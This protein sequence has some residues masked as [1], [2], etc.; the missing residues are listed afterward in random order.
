MHTFKE[1]ILVVIIGLTLVMVSLATA[2]AV[3][4]KDG[5]LKIYFLDVGQGDAILIE[6]P[7]GNQVLIDGGPD[8]KILSEL[9]KVMPFY[10]QSIDA[11]VVSHPHS[12]HIT[13]LTEV[14]A[15]YEVSNII[16][17]NENYDSPTFRSW[18]AAVTAEHTHE[19]EA[20]A[21]TK[22]ALAPEVILT[23]IHP[24]QSVAGTTTKTP[25]DDVVVAVLEYRSLRVLLTGDM[26]VKVERS[27]IGHGI[28]LRAD[29]LKIGHHGSSTSTSEE[30][31]ETVDPQVAVI[32]VGDKNRYHHPTTSVLDRL[33]NFQVQYYRTDVHGAITLLSNGESFYINK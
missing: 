19:M 26:E 6:A 12:D 30:F 11:V 17:A 27:L 8:G 2:R 14:L 25:H 23:I 18:Q 20:V 28:D 22:I 3:A 5:L 7:N 10:D 32:E 15:R 9:A 33:T 4:Q 29:V 24:F 1:K 31:L 16:Q 13:G 21:G